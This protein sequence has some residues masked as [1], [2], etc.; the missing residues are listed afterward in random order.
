M[1]TEAIH[2]LRGCCRTACRDPAYDHV[3]D[4]FDVNLVV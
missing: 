3:N 1:R 4:G 2:G